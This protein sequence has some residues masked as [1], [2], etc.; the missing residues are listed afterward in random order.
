MPYRKC[1]LWV[2]VYV[3]VKINLH[4]TVFMLKQPSS[5]KVQK[6]IG[7]NLQLTGFPSSH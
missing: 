1:E 3:S 5:L 7:L 6:D 4:V 2:V